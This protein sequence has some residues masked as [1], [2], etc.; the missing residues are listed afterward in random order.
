MK[1]AWTAFLGI[2][3]VSS[4]C[5]AA[6]KPEIKSE[7]DRVNYSIGYQIGGDF[8]RQGWKLNPDLLVQGIR[9]AVAQADP[10]M[11]RKEMNST[12]VSLKKQVTADQQEKAK[13]EDAAF[14][15]ENAKRAGVV[16]LPSGVQYKVIKEGTGKQPGLK[17]Q[18]TVRYQVGRVDGLTKTANAPDGKPRTYPLKKALPGLQEVLQLMKEGSVWQVVLPPGPALGT[19]GEALESAGVLVYELELVSVQPGS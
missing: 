5:L 18:V 6:D 7:T 15:A 14:L 10:L 4:V 13:K 9:D 11:S 2:L 12:L 19:R 16:V 17:D 1:T 3:L 8:L